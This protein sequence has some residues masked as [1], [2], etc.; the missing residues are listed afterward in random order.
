MTD[1]TIGER[2][3]RV[4]EKIDTIEE[5]A[6]VREEKQDQILEKLNAIELSMASTKSFMGGAIYV[7]SAMVM[8]LYKIGPWLYNFIKAKTG[9]G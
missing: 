3:V 9:N 8:V 4:E 1:Y 6:K 7:G 2:L 5:Q